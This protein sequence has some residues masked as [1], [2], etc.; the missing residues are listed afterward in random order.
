MAIEAQRN[1]SMPNTLTIYHNPRCSKSREA[2]TFL[3]DHGFL[4]KVIEYLKTPP[5]TADLKRLHNMLN[6][7]VRDMLRKKEEVYKEFKLDDPKLSDDQI[8]KIV[9]KHP[10]LLERPIV[11]F[12]HKAAIIRP[13]E[14]IHQ[15]MKVK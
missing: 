2:L 15:L 5:T 4:P 13:L 14:V 9:T 10:I 7:P 8:F 6:I 1:P 3:T 12:N 11:I